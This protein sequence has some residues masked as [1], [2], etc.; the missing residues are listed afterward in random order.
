MQKFAVRERSLFAQ[1]AITGDDAQRRI[2]R[3][4]RICV[5]NELRKLYGD[6]PKE[7]IPPDMADLLHR[8]DARTSSRARNH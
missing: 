8:L 3:A 2:A 5:G 6:P 7:P 4:L 1:W